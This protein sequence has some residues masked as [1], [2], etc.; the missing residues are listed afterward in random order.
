MFS[1][2]ITYV[3]KQRQALRAAGRGRRRLRR[4]DDARCRTSRSSRRRGRPTAR[5]LAYVSFE[6]KKPVVYVQSLIDRRAPG[7]GEFL[8]Q[9]QRAGLVARRQAARGGAHQGRRLADLSHQRRRRR[10]HAPDPAARRSTPSPISPR[11]GEL[12]AVHLRPRRQPADLRHAGDGRRAA[13]GSRSRAAT[14]SRRASAPTARAS[15]SYSGTAARFNVAVQ[16][17]ATRQV[18]VLTDGAHRRVAELRAE[19]PDDSLRNRGEG[20]WYIVRGLERRPG[21]AAAHRGCRRCARAG[22][23]PAA[24][25]S[26]SVTR[27]QSHEETIAAAVLMLGHARG[28]Q[29]HPHQGA[30]RRRGRGPQPAGA[31]WS[32]GRRSSPVGPAPPPSR[33]WTSRLRRQP[34]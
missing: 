16:D 30:G 27:S 34:R 10:R 3:V 31:R 13:S 15:R 6:Q 29:Q 14:T 9:Q 18:Q 20:A 7:G 17:L 28:V 5:A 23:G 21:E 26:N 8:G 33:S 2:R 22:M 24:E 32:T 25:M 19:R 11:T 1:T 4:A 12:H